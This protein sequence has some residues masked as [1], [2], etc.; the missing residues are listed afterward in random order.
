MEPS[1]STPKA[2]VAATAS[3]SRALSLVAEPAGS[4]YQVGRAKLGGFRGS[5][6]SEKRRWPKEP[7]VPPQEMRQARAS[8][9]NCPH[10]TQARMTSESFHRRHFSAWSFLTSQGQRKSS[11]KTGI[12]SVC[13]SNTGIE[14]SLMFSLA[15]KKLLRCRPSSF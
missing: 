13:R 3:C 15:G 1:R 7:K 9:G 10:V 5:G 2:Q 12:R 14:I 4:C 8:E 11:T 6:P